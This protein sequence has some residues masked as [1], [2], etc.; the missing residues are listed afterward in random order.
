MLSPVA[1]NITAHKE[2]VKPPPRG[3][4]KPQAVDFHECG[5]CRRYESAPREAKTKRRRRATLVIV[6]RSALISALKEEFLRHSWRNVGRTE[7]YCGRCMVPVG[8]EESF[9]AHI[10]ND[11]IPNLIHRLAQTPHG[12]E[13][14][15]LIA[16]IQA[17]WDRHSRGVFVHDGTTRFGCVQCRRELPTHPAFLDHTGK[18]IARM[19]TDRAKLKKQKPRRPTGAFLFW[20]RLLRTRRNGR[21]VCWRLFPRR[22]YEHVEAILPFRFIHLIK[23]NPN[24]QFP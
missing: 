24:Q 4:P 21:D 16:A 22:H 7:M 1:A 9:F 11:A 12:A 8:P 13:A 14:A 17:E 15:K 5:R 3:Y 23:E 20:R 2:S 10:R 19:L 6:R 18:A